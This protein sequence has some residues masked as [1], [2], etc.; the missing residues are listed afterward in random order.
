LHKR[1]RENS[2][3]WK[4]SF[5]IGAVER[6]GIRLLAARRTFKQQTRGAATGTALAIIETDQKAVDAA[7]NRKTAGW[8]SGRWYA[9]GTSTSS[10]E[11][12][13]GRHHFTWRRQGH[14]RAVKTYRLITELERKDIMNIEPRNLSNTM[15]EE[16]LTASGRSCGRLMEAGLG[17]RHQLKHGQR[18]TW[19]SQ[20][21]LSKLDGHEKR[22][23]RKKECHRNTL[24]LGW[25]SAAF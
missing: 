13:Q 6:I 19:R 8:G 24:P 5:F 10:Y 12:G 21:F 23:R 16:E 18:A 14:C 17:E 25:F 2:K 22:S 7:W 15:T 3:S 20:V 4:N 11:A 1:Q 9:G